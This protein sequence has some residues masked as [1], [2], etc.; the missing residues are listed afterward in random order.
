[1]LPLLVL[2][3][4]GMAQ[5]QEDAAFS[6]FQLNRSLPG[7]RSLAMGGSFV[8]VADDASA[9]YANPAGLTLL[10]RREVSVE[11]RGWQDN[12]QFSDRGR[13]SGQPTGIGIDT[14]P[15]IVRRDGRS[16]TS[17]VSFASYVDAANARRWVLAAY[18]RTY[19]RFRARFDSQGVFS[20]DPNIPRFGPYRF[21]TTFDVDTFGVAYAYQF[22]DCSEYLHCLRLGGTLSDY[23]LRLDSTEDVLQRPADNGP[24][25]F[26]APLRGSA[27]RQ[28]RGDKL[29]VNLGLMY[30]FG[31]SIRTGLAYRQVP[32]FSISENIFG[33]HSMHKLALPY[34]YSAGVSWRN[35][36]DLLLSIEVDRVTYSR[37]TAG[38]TFSR[39]RLNDGW[40]SRLGGEWTAWQNAIGDKLI[41]MAG[42]WYD[43]DHHL[44]FQGPI[45]T[46]IDLFRRAYFPGGTGE[47][48]GSAG[49]GV[50]WQ[51]FQTNLAADVSGQTRSFS[52]SEIYRFRG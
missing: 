25:D 51:R 33:S 7:G 18:Y 20:S 29:G 5:A 31:S 1:M 38:N 46:D 12:F 41:V 3:A 26:G 6:A 15:G 19:A 42:L 37:L 35:R 36:R 21:D 40:E 22:G 8:A 45:T 34:E 30:E 52:L 24:A 11:G 14:F 43:P 47:L 16:K 10:T 48:H 2:G 32:T 4:I 27:P 49:V 13:V 17:S 9:A 23:S 44:T 28:G 50:H 39:L